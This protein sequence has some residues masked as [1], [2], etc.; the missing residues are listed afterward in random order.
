MAIISLYNNAY[1]V[2]S[3]ETIETDLFLNAIKEGR[4]QDIV[5]KNR[6]ITDKKKRKEAAAKTFPRVTL[7]GKFNSKKDS[8]LDKHSGFIGI[9]I[10]D[11]EDTEVFDQTRKKLASDRY[12]YSFFTSKSGFGICAIF[13][14]VPSKHRQA[15]L[16]ISEYLFKTY[17]IIA[18]PSCINESRTRDVSYDPD[19]YLN[20]FAEK[21]EKYPKSKPPKKI[22]NAV[23]FDDDFKRIIDQVTN[24]HLNLCEEYQ[25]WINIGFALAHQFGENGL[26]YFHLVSQYSDKYNQSKCERQY[27]SILRHKASYKHI[28]IATFYYY[29]KQAGITVVSEKS[30]KVIQ[31]AKQGKNSGL[32]PKQI[33]DNLKKFE[34]IDVAPELIEKVNSSSIAVPDQLDIIPQM[35]LFLRSNYNL[36]RNSITRMIENEGKLIDTI[37]M[38]SVEVRLRKSIP[39]ATK[40]LFNL[41]IGSDFIPTYNPFFDFIESNKGMVLSGGLISKVARCIDTIDKDYAEFFFT[42]WMVAMIASIHGYH[43]PL[44]P[45]LSGEVQGKG[46]T[47][48]FRRLLPDELKKYVG[49]V[50][51]GI[52]DNDFHILMT[53]CLV[54]LDDECGGKSKKD[55]MLQKSMLSKQYF[56][57]REPYGRSNVILQRIAMMCGTTNQSEILNDPTGNRRFIPIK[58]N[59][60]DFNAYNSVDK[61]EMFMEAYNLYKQ[62]YNY[63]LTSAD[64]KYLNTYETEFERIDS[65][66]EL[67]QKYYIP[68]EKREGTPM[69]TTDIKVFIEKES[70]QKLSLT[71]IGLELKKLGFEQDFEK[72]NKSSRRYYYVKE[73]GL[74]GSASSAPKPD[75][76]VSEDLPY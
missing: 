60:Y 45:I 23:F 31:S 4:W 56:N 57:L 21:F 74:S 61:T 55:E 67:I 40:E 13:K 10:D 50:S 32:A 51:P 15:F 75:F 66:K 38:N 24:N 52:K 63:E 70:N 58:F 5:F 8:E 17:D 43:S 72:V 59:S 27:K 22:D 73:T 30:K 28:T 46:K 37:A 41:L 54:I 34:G 76:N 1:D 3:Q 48:F 7:S 69:T 19:L 62:G 36:R 25:D 16:G 47:E 12:V 35:E 71:R 29:C 26:Q 18:D 14:I 44:M 49:E 42:K 68:C 64:I 6:L 65:A 11:I 2:N 39:K 33:A 9:D 53:Q 20:Q